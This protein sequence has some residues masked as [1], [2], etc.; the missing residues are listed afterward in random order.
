MDMFEFIQQ[1]FKEANNPTMVP[2]FTDPRSD[3]QSITCATNSYHII[4]SI[5]SSHLSQLINRKYLP[6][7]CIP[8][9]SISKTSD[10]QMMTE[11]IR[12]ASSTWTSAQYLAGF[13]VIDRIYLTSCPHC[14]VDTPEDISHFVFDCPFF[15]PFRSNH[16]NQYSIYDSTKDCDKIS[17]LLKGDYTLWLTSHRIFFLNV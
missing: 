15:Q 1:H 6:T 17:F 9:I 10:F 7:R 14:G 8:Y 12:I 3:I 5:K 2:R 16:F 4:N 11:L 13:G